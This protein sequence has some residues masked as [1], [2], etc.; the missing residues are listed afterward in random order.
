M[1]LSDSFESLL[2]LV[3]GATLLVV[4][5]ELR[6]RIQL[7]GLIGSVLGFAA[8]V[9]AY[10]LPVWGTE[11][12]SLEIRNPAAALNTVWLTYHVA[13]IMPSYGAFFVSFG[14]GVGYLLIDNP[15]VETSWR[16]RALAMA[17]LNLQIVRIGFVLLTLGI[18][19]GAIWADT[20][21]GRPWGWDAKETWA[22]VTWLFYLVYLHLPHVLPDLLRNRMHACS[23]SERKVARCLAVASIAFFPVVLFTYFGV[24][25]LLPGLHAY[26]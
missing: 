12:F 11:V 8:L 22:L 19:F 20:C 18:A 9:L 4:I 14:L 6:Y 16:H 17:R 5:F 15:K 2:A 26:G 25:F 21:W 13:T 23:S 7:A 1:P 3:W 24:N 10:H